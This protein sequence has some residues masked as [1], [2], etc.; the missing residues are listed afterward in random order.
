[1]GRNQIDKCARMQALRGGWPETFS[2]VYA[3]E[4]MDRAIAQ[5]LTASEM[6]E[7]EREDRRKKTIAMLDDEYPFVDHE[8]T[9]K[10]ISA[11]RYGDDILIAAHK[12]IKPEELESMMV[13]NREGLQRFWAKHKDDALQVRQELDK[14]GA[15]LKK[16]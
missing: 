1:M 7:Q 14:I 6:V 2:G 16:S 3:P 10:F 15:G 12:C 13:R 5:D 8:G 11:G 9:L 4:E